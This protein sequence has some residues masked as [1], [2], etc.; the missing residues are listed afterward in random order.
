[1]RSDMKI[2]PGPIEPIRPE[3]PSGTLKPGRAERVTGP[4]GVDG[5]AA[6]ARIQAL[7]TEAVRAAAEVRAD[8][9][10]A[11]RAQIQAGQFK[12]D[13]SAIADAIIEGI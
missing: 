4:G 11:V 3:R 1:M 10:A 9:V 13:A 8:R 6:A 7:A 5:V 12:I 2:G